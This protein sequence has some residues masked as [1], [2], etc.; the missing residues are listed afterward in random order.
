MCK[1]ENSERK[2][3]R[4]DE[5]REF[6]GHPENLSTPARLLSPR[7]SLNMILFPVGLLSLALAILGIFLPLLPTT[8]FVLLAACCFA[9]TSPKFH[10]WMINHQ[11]FGPL[12][13]NWQEHGSIS[14]RAKVVSTVMIVPIVGVSLMRVELPIEVIILVVAMVTMALWFIWSRP[15]QEEGR[16]R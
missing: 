16:D 10:A 15:S 8:P 2:Q 12:I 5:K 13:R 3:E 14:N 7:G 1:N 4:D 6:C 9:R 11:L